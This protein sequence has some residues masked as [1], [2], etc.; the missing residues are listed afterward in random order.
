MPASKD[1]FDFFG[2]V[3]STSNVVVDLVV[4]QFSGIRCH[5]CFGVECFGGRISCMTQPPMD[6]NVV[7]DH[8][9]DQQI[10]RGC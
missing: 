5:S 1:G 9:V 3:D 6:M 2:D 8:R 10:H 4:V 7:A